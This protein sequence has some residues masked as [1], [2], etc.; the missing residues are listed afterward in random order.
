MN[1]DIGTCSMG[2][3]KSNRPAR[4]LAHV[5][6]ICI[7]SRVPMFG[8]NTMHFQPTS[9]DIS[10]VR[11]WQMVPESIIYNFLDARTLTSSW[12]DV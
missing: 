3:W 7:P 2:L 6:V 9:N 10:D 11:R 4:E 5:L 12:L 8:G 1:G